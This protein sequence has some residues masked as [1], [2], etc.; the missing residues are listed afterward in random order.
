MPGGSGLELLEYVRK[1]KYNTMFVVQ[2]AAECYEKQ[3]KIKEFE[4]L[5][6]HAWHLHK[7]LW[8]TINDFS[9]QWGECDKIH[10]VNKYNLSYKVEE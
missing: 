2:L 4:E 10:L 1:E 3:R 6:A 9:T 5:A 8:D 7:K